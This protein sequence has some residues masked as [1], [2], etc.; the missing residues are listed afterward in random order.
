MTQSHEGVSLA[1]EDCCLARSFT[2]RDVLAALAHPR[3]VAAWG[4]AQEDS[5]SEVCSINH[6]ARRLALVLPLP[7]NLKEES[8]C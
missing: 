7:P 1:Q 6:R 8:P 4:E 3:A 2:V 5:M